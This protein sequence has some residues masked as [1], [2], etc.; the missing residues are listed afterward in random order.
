MK[1]LTKE[2]VIK[3][4][5]DHELRW[6]TL[7]NLDVL[8][9]QLF[10]WPM[11]KQPSDPEQVT[12]PE[13]QAYVLSPHHPGDKSQKDRIKDHLRKWHPDRFETKLL[14]KVREDEREKVKEGAG[15][16]A[17]HLNK[18]LSSLSGSAENGLFG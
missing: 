7:A 14:P 18:L 15:A 2:Q 11:L 16:V 8:S 12:Y 5:E 1:Q 17:R 9:W 3:L 10:P 4:F 6:A 13:V